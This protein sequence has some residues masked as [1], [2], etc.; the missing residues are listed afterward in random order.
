MS[1]LQ[2]RTAARLAIIALHLSTTTGSWDNLWE[3]A[4]SVDL[5][6]M[7]D[8]YDSA[9]SHVY[10]VTAHLSRQLILQRGP[11]DVHGGAGLGVPM[12][13]QGHTEPAV[14]AAAEVANGPTISL[15][16]RQRGSEQPAD[17]SPFCKLQL[18]TCNRHKHH[19]RHTAT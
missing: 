7:A 17:C 16:T 15:H 18:M 8:D 10:V 11:H 3:V 13:A 1:A 2:R 14:H 9:E 4:S 12:P 5:K 6:P 19:N